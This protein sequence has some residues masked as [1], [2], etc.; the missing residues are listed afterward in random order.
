MRRGASCAR[1]SGLLDQ[2]DVGSRAAIA[3]RR[4]ARVHFNDGVVHAHGGKRG[5][6]VLDG[7]HAHRAFANGGGAFDCF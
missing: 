4:F 6:N 7:V 3:D 1:D 2:L 5:E